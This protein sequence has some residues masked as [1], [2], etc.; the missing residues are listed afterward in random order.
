VCRIEILILNQSSIINHQSICDLLKYSTLITYTITDQHGD[1]EL[2]GRSQI[3]EV[4]VNISFLGYENYTKLVDLSEGEI[5]LGDIK[6]ALAENTLGEVILKSRAPITVK[7]DTLEFNVSSFKT[8]QDA[9]IEDLLKELPGVEVNDAGEI[10]INGKP[11]D[12][13]LVNGKPFFGDDPTIATRNLTKEIVEKIQVVDT[14]TDDEAFSG[15]DGDQE[16]KTINLTISE[17]K[18]KGVFG[19]LAAGGGTDERFEYAGIINAFDNDRRISILGG[20]NNIN[21]PGFNF[22]EIYKI[23]GGNSGVSFSDNGSFTVGSRSF[24]GAQGIVNSRSAG[25]NYTDVYSKNVDASLDYFY[26]QIVIQTQ[27]LMEITIV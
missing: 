6:I 8:K 26:S 14:K 12:K 10:T 5:V 24:G 18:N 11:V 22:G 20:G 23:F 27:I 19:R 4:R 13:I 9:N 16:N 25:G 1:F 3:K 15:D 17:E 7:K 21:A 2:E